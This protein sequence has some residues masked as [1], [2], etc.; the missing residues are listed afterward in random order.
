MKKV[1][2]LVTISCVVILAV[3]SLASAASLTGVYD[4]RDQLQG[5]PTVFEGLTFTDDGTLWI[6][7]APDTASDPLSLF[8]PDTLLEVQLDF[9]AKTGNVANIS[10]YNQF[11][12]S[13]SP[14]GLASDGTNIFVANNIGDSVYTTTTTGIATYLS[15]DINNYGCNEPEGSAYLGGF[16]YIGCEDTQNILKLDPSTGL[17]VQNIAL[18]V[19]VL[20]LGATDDGALII[21]DY[22]NHD[23]LIYDV[24]TN[25]VR[26]TIDLESLFV[27]YEVEV[28]PDDIRHVPDPDGLAYRDGKIYMTFEHDL[29]VYEITIATPEPGTLLLIGSGLLALA[30]LRRKR[31]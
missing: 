4:L 15:N 2:S 10:P 26:E 19:S 5:T 18:G 25:N 13:F 30:G 7:S 14:V 6:T 21:G 22:T 1:L 23:I 11:T 16:V 29:Q 28:T 9:D 3:A 24:A 12:W 27:N 20:G 31:S 17:V 8:L